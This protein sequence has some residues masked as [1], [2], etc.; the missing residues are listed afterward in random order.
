MW[1]LQAL[2][3][4]RGIGGC[5]GWSPIEEYCW[6]GHDH[7]WWMPRRIWRSIPSKA[8]LMSIPKMLNFFL[9]FFTTASIQRYVHI[10][11]AVLRPCRNRFGWGEICF[12]GF[13]EAIEEIYW[14]R[15]FSNVVTRV[16][17]ESVVCWVCWGGGAVFVQWYPWIGEF[18]KYG[19][20][21]QPIR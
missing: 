12:K 3:L 5:V 1:L 2:S 6:W 9:Y 19:C 15:V 20:I 13:V 17:R 8:L 21:L 10:I 16:F 11:S 7:Q 18:R 4:Q 14:E